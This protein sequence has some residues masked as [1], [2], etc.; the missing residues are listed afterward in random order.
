M[1]F[2]SRTRDETTDTPCICICE[3][4]FLEQAITLKESALQNTRLTIDQSR[5][6]SQRNECMRYHHRRLI[7][8]ARCDFSKQ[9]RSEGNG[10]R[11]KKKL[12]FNNKQYGYGT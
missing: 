5:L 11:D 12:L 2:L 7:T 8:C 10:G 9:R 6:L 3:S 4:Q 1:F